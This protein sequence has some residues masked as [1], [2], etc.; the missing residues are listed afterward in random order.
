VL[1]SGRD[2]KTKMNEFE[3][4]ASRNI[5]QFIGRA[6]DRSHTFEGLTDCT[7]PNASAH[8]GRDCHNITLWDCHRVNIGLHD[9]KPAV[10]KIVNC[11]DVRI[12]ARRGVICEIDVSHSQNVELD[13]MSDDP[14]SCISL[15][16]CY[17]GDVMLYCYGNP[18]KASCTASMRLA[19]ARERAWPKLQYYSDMF[20]HPARI[21]IP[22]LEQ[23]Y[24]QMAA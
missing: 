19:C 5:I 24:R 10:I 20:D 15:D 6:H 1:F 2:Q 16:I 7:I 23:I 17:S 18:V 4:S 21:W 8:A 22:G 14:N 11:S 3:I 9:I 13:V 12:V